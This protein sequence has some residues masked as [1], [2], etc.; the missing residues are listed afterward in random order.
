MDLEEF[1]QDLVQV[2]IHAAQLSVGHLD[3]RG[4]DSQ[5]GAFFPT[6]ATVGIVDQA[7]DLIGG[8]STQADPGLG[9]A[10]E[11]GDVAVDHG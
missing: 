10:D 5:L 11:V 9:E 4:I 2:F 8:C 1:R 3:R 6:A 7:L